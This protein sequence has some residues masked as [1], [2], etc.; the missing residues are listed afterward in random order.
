MDEPAPVLG[1][2]LYVIFNSVPS[3]HA[4]LPRSKG[5]SVTSLCLA[6]Q[7]IICKNPLITAVQASEVA[8]HGLGTPSLRSLHA[9]PN[10]LVEKG[11]AR[12]I[13]PFDTPSLIKDHVG[14]NQHLHIGRIC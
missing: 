3:V 8:R 12:R 13:Q 10:A 7:Q 9:T 14:D 6:L 2:V 1:E 11:L 4:T 5:V